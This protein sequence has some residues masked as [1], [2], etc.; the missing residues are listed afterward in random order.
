MDCGDSEVC[1][2]EFLSKKNNNYDNKPVN[3]YTSSECTGMV[4]DKKYCHVWDSC[5]KIGGRIHSRLL[6]VDSLP[7]QACSDGK[8]G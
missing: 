3:L 8:V 6:D 5:G 4:G 1:Q 2:S 7:T